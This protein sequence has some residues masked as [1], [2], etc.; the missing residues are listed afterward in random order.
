MATNAY[1]ERLEENRQRKVEQNVARLNTLPLSKPLKQ[2]L[3]GL[4]GGPS[5][6]EPEKP[7]LPDMDSFFGQYVNRELQGDTRF[8]K[9]MQEYK[10][11]ALGFREEVN[12]GWMPPQIA[13][14][15]LKQYIDDNAQWF[16]QNKRTPMDNPQMQEFMKNLAMKVQQEKQQAGPSQELPNQEIADAVTEGVE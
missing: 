8:Q 12:Q 15:R 2:Q 13:Q 4:A 7:N 3:S 6:P 14:Q 11:L 1:T 5:V 9:M 10:D 16:D